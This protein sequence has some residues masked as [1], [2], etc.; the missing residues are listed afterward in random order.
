M[1]RRLAL[2]LIVLAWA[3]LD[4]D[5]DTV[6]A[7]FPRDVPSPESV[8]TRMFPELPPFAPQTDAVRNAVRLLG[9]RGGL[10][11]AL[12]NLSDPMQ[13]VV[14][15]AFS[16]NNPNNAAMT[17]GMTF[18]GQ[19]L[20]HD[21]TLDLRSRLL[22]R[23]E[24]RR[25]ANFRTAAFDLDSLYGDGPERSSELYELRGGDVRFRVESI[26]GAAAVSSLGAGRFDVPR[27]GA[28]EAIIADSRNDENVIL[29]QLHVAMLRFHN[30]V[31]DH[32]RARAENQGAAPRELFRKARRL[33]QWHYQW[34]I[35]NEFLP[36]TIGQERLDAILREGPKYYDA[37]GRGRDG[38]EGRGARD[39]GRRAEPRIPVEFSAA[40]YRFGH[41]QVRP[42]YRLNFGPTGGPAF[43]AFVFDDRLDPN[44]PDPADLRGGRRAPR[45][46]VDWQ[47]FFDF[48]DGNARPNKRIDSKISTPL[49]ELPGSRAP[50]PGLP[51]DGVQS[52]P[53]RNLIRHVNF[54]LPSGQAIARHIGV[55]ALTSAQL[56]EL[57]P[58]KLADSTPLWYYIL[59]EAE[60]LEGG[61]R[62]GPVGAR[63]VGEVFVGLLKADRDSYLADAPNWKPTLPA[64]GGPGTF[65]M[66]DLLRFAGVV[67]PLQ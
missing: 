27:D 6:H 4:S 7:R 18:L 66:A 53:S 13:S 52:L 49:M 50:A 42:S 17:A 46:F 63:I 30:A 14:N 64:A 43:F 1:N 47:T 65:R 19:F 21:V 16:P 32:L 45:R 9:A 58:L 62:L 67:P 26:P 15:P 60:L 8:F 25:T 57:A 38:R 59:K 39:N 22:E 37:D 40:A 36:L 51:T 31:T 54:G 48:G 34:I 12:D 33:V 35:V 5:A 55:T 20:D 2:P 61:A 11:D 10:L 41:S 24:P 29:S 23:A 28:G 44:D 3:A 56:A